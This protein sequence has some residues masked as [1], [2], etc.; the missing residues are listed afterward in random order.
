[1][2]TFQ[3][4]YEILGIARDADADA[5][6]KAYRKLAMQWHPDKHQG[7]AKA[8]AEERFKRIAE[9]YEVLGDPEK[10][11]RYDRFGEHWQHGQEF[12]PG[13][14]QAGTGSMS[15]EEFERAFGG[16]FSD[17]FSQ[18]FGRQYS[19]QFDRASRHRPRRPHRGA[20]L[21]A[22]LEVPLATAL[23]GG[24][25]TFELPTSVPCPRCGGF[26][27]VEQH[28]CP[29]CTGLGA[30]RETRR[31]ELSVPEDIRDGMTVRLRGMGQAGEEGGESGD[32]LLRLHLAGDDRL[33]MRGSDIEADV[34]VAPWDCLAGT[35]ISVRTA[36]ADV[37]VKIPP[38]TRAG[39]RLRLRG[40]GFRDGHGG[41]GDFYVVVR[42]ALP[43]T[44]S[45]RQ[46]DL[47]IQAGNVQ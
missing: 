18:L 12:T 32:L 29:T 41:R 9:A 43:A 26:G 2:V 15:R 31:V 46:R 23:R 13:G 37:D 1:M 27:F 30:V 45:E 21:R 22:D 38:N 3:D 6:K 36:A 28:V 39:A 42:M 44:L 33:R 4:Y 34:D 11:S 19:D 25:S 47:L 16:G 20:D 5:V 14:E 24:K 40:Q 35:R 17:F 10:R 8:A 7:D